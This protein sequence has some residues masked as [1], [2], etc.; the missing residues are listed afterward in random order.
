MNLLQEILDRV[1]MNNSQDGPMIQQLRN[2]VVAEKGNQSIQQLYARGIT[3]N[4]S[5][6]TDARFM[7][8]QPVEG[9]ER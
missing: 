7:G 1:I 5:P 9:D 6:K 2:Q 8:R 3:A 4:H